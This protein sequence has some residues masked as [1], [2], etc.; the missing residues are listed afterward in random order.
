M[1]VGV[2]RGCSARGDPGS[3]DL[4]QDSLGPL[5][6]TSATSYVL[7]GLCGFPNLNLPEIPLIHLFYRGTKLD[8]HVQVQGVGLVLDFIGG[9]GPGT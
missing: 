9:I 3:G 6:S 5:W 2:G 7:R 4:G 8:R 1:C